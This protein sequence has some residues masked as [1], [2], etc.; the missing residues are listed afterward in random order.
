VGARHEELLR[1]GSTYSS[2]RMARAGPGPVA[3]HRPTS[4]YLGLALAA[5]VAVAPSS[6]QDTH[7]LTDRAPH[8]DH[9]LQHPYTPNGFDIPHW[10]FTGDTSVDDKFIR[11][12][13]DRQSKRGALWNTNPWDPKSDTSKYPPFEIHM[14][15][16]VNGQGTKLF[17][18]GFALWFTKKRLQEGSVFGSEDGFTGMSITFDT[19][20]NLNQGLQQYVSVIIGDGSQEYD[21]DKDGGDVKLAGCENAFRG[22]TT[23]AKIVYDGDLLRM[24]L[25]KPE[26][27][28]HECFIVRRVRLPRGYFFGFSAATGELADNHDIISFKVYDPPSMESA[29][30]ADIR[31]RIEMDIEAGV[32]TEEHHDPQYEGRS[33]QAEH[34]DDLPLWASISL[35]VVLA[36]IIIAAYFLA[37]KEPEKTNAL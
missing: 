30:E 5:A 6:A 28:W 22:V 9:L 13:P 15:F 34:H 14:T 10:D 18:D 19:Y 33:K 32:E 16:N 26:E 20:S 4:L 21:H 37:S 1:Y 27:P 31:K 36:I 35:F 2:M 11:L 17:G 25:A 29:E 8:A 7:D 12:T 23:D 3:T 24:Y